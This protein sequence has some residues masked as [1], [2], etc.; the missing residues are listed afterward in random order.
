MGKRISLS[1]LC[2]WLYL[3]REYPFGNLAEKPA[4][5]NLSR[6]SFKMIVSWGKHWPWSPGVAILF[7]YFVVVVSTRFM[8]QACSGIWMSYQLLAWYKS[9]LKILVTIELF[10]QRC[11]LDSQSIFL[12][13]YVTFYTWL[14]VFT[15]RCNCD[16]TVVITS[17]GSYEVC[18]D[19]S[20]QCGLPAWFWTGY[21]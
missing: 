16:V 8:D 1:W 13:N 2:V 21:H 12:V 20:E 4:N 6:S 15:E 9:L 7:L 17:E 14:L 3:G 18:R 5:T 11:C 19:W 10:L